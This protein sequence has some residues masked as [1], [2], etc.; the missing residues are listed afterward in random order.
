MA[1]R[2][3]V[4]AR[5]D[6]AYDYEASGKSSLL[7]WFDRDACTDV[8][9][10]ATRWD[11]NNHRGVIS[12]LQLGCEQLLRTGKG[13][14]VHYYDSHNE[15]NGPEYYEFYTDAQAKDWLLRAETPQAEAAVEKYFGEIEEESGPNLGGRPAVGKKVEMRLDEATLAQVDA[16]AADASVSRAEMLRRLVVAGL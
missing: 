13:R 6:N 16:R 8:I 4:Y 11:G 3:N 12:D 7:G 15:F 9:D 1:P 14:W 2:I 5:G 10:E